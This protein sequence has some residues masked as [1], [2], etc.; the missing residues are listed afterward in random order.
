[1][2]FEDS[3]LEGEFGGRVVCDPADMP[4]SGSR[5]KGRRFHLGMYGLLD[6]GVGPATLQFKLGPIALERQ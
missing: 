1:M 5:V 2:A 6:S 4:A 3:T